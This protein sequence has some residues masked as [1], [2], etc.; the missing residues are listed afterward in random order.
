[1][2]GIMSEGA[3]TLTRETDVRGANLTHGRMSSILNP[4]VEQ[5]AVE[6]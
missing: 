2:D 1:M 5:S 4:E 6:E 3:C